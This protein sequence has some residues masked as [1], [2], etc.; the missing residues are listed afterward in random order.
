MPTTVL[1]VQQLVVGNNR[2][3]CYRKRF[4]VHVCYVQSY[5]CVFAMCSVVHLGGHDYKSAVCGCIVAADL[6]NEE[7]AKRVL[8]IIADV[9]GSI[10]RRLTSSPVVHMSAL[11]LLCSM[12]PWSLGGLPLHTVLDIPGNLLDMLA[13]FEHGDK[14]FVPCFQVHAGATGSLVSST[15]SAA[16]CCMDTTVTQQKP[17][18]TSKPT[19]LRQ[20]AFCMHGS[21]CGGGS[22]ARL[23]LIQQYC[24]IFT[25]KLAAGW[26]AASLTAL[27]LRFIDGVENLPGA[28]TIPHPQ[29]CATRAAITTG[30]ATCTTS[31]LADLPCVQVLWEVNTAGNHSAHVLPGVQLPCTE[32]CLPINCCMIAVVIHGWQ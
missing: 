10:T 23:S 11:C 28:A 21:N 27:L 25:I 31:P 18:V 15:H 17:P 29:A 30:C 6:P 8:S 2:P 12:V 3:A 4:T 22:T 16:D 32:Q 14:P 26:S 1:S 24:C 20:L 9:S 7:H 19:D 13:Y 5:H